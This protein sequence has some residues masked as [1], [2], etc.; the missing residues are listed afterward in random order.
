MSG[1][2]YTTINMAPGEP[3]RVGVSI[4]PDEQT[5][6]RYYPA[7]NDAHAFISV[8]YGTAHVH[9]GTTSQT[10]VTDAHVTFAR[11]LLDAAAAFLAHCE[12]QST[13]QPATDT[14]A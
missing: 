3:T 11:Q 6:V 2:S 14:A 12:Q 9:I 13:H 4:Y 1:Y 8:D 10:P 7:K 5:R